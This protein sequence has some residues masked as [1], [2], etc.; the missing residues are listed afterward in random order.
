MRRLTEDL[1]SRRPQRALS[2]RS[3][4]ARELADRRGHR[5]FRALGAPVLGGVGLRPSGG[6][7]GA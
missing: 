3:V 4:R 7:P 1:N 2:G 6:G 5:A